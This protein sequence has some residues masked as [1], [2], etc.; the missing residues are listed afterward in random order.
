MSGDIDVLDP[1]LREDH[2]E[3]LKKPPMYKVI[4]HNDDFTP[5][6]FV[7]QLLESHFAKSY[8]EAAQL[9]QQTHKTGAAIVGVYTRDIAETRTMRAMGDVYREG[10]PLQIS[11]ES[12]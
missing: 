10:H 5:M 9:A 3:R 11:V 1:T 6:E 12:E 4:V 2:D 8:E 7:I